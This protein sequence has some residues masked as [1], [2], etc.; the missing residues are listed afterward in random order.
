MTSAP[1]YDLHKLGWRAFQDLCSI[2]LQ[3][4][5]GQTFSTFAD[6]NDGGRD[7]AF[8]GSWSTDVVGGQ[9]E[10]IPAGQATVLQCK[11]SAAPGGT[12]GP[13]SLADEI[14]KVKKL[15]S[16]GLCD[17][18]I[19]MTNLRVSGKTEAWMRKE[20][21]SIGVTTSVALDGRWIAQQI[22]KWPSLRRYV[23]RVYGLGDLGQILDGRRLA[24]ANALLSRLG[25]DLGTFVPTSAYRQAASALASHAFVLLL[26]PPAA[27]KST[28]AATLAMAALDEWGDSVKRVDSAAELVEAWNPNEPHQL[29]WVDD[30]FGAIRHDARLTDD[31]ARR[32]DQ[33]MTAIKGGARIVLTSRDYIY[34]Q[35]RVYLKTYAYPLLR[36]QTVVVDVAQLTRREKRQILYNHVKAGDQ[37]AQV[38]RIWK[39]VFPEVADLTT[40]QPE[41]ARRIGR[42]AFTPNVHA[43]KDVVALFEHPVDFL[44]DVLEQIEPQALVALAMVFLAGERLA[45]PLALSERQH[46]LAASAGISEREVGDALRSLEGTFLAEEST[47]GPAGWRFRHP[48]IREGFAAVAVADPNLTAT[49]VEGLTDDEL[50]LQVD[51]GTDSQGTLLAVPAVM[52]RQVALRT[53][54]SRAT[55]QSHE[56]T[57][58]LADFLLR[59][60]SDDF[61][62]VW[63]EVNEGGL[64]GL[65]DFDYHLGP[66]WRPR[67]LARLRSAGALPEDLRLQAV[68]VL[69]RNAVELLD[70]SWIDDSIQPVL[71]PAEVSH[72]RNRVL[73]EVLPKLRDLVW[74]SAD[75]YGAEVSA[76]DRYSHAVDA[77]TAFQKEFSAE[78]R[79]LEGI[80]ATL[81]SVH[82]S[83]GEENGDY[84]AP[85]QTS[86]A[87]IV[88]ID[89]DTSDRDEF[90]DVEA[91]HA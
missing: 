29:F 38:L 26:G 37:P 10:I 85:R 83:I 50:V 76:S 8:Y 33:V 41:I 48:T 32:M 34:R 67:V 81:Q 70:Y 78:P 12:L 57:P 60:C 86:F 1:D 91:G 14:A 7:G 25:D 77:L 13:S 58:A 3:E 49:V 2:V 84:F 23:P 6:S 51:C 22:S 61:L 46:A 16:Q 66:S 53:P 54:L 27:G 44:V 55:T 90:E 88:H 43:N 72:I 47:L 28:I 62:R 18:Y 19:L 82:E 52:Y 87:P 24:Q 45:A 59:R 21:S 9:G 17:A 71:E 75:G 63:V 39:R 64:A 36:E 79:V 69:E 42:R 74:E 56:W 20:L 35:A 5:L 31:W 4:V 40:F 11:F 15:C 65:V 89:G 68:E 80:E 30:A 73:T